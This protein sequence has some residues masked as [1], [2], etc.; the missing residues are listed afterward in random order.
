MSVVNEHIAAERNGG[1]VVDAASAV[2]YIP[3]DDRERVR[4]AKIWASVSVCRI[5]GLYSPFDDVRDCTRKHL[6]AFRHL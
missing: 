3:H 2:C 6:E 5:E 4:E 1:V